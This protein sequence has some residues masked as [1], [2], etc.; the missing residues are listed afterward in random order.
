MKLDKAELTLLCGLSSS[1]LPGEGLVTK[2][3]VRIPL[4]LWGKLYFF[5]ETVSFVWTVLASLPPP[6]FFVQAA[7]A[8][9]S[10]P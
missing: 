9:M 8:D 4:A 3:R 10:F 2:R 7:G 6:V 1:A 5:W